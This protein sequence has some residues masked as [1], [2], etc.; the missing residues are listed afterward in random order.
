MTGVLV[1]QGDLRW[2]TQIR[3]IL[4]EYQRDERDSAYNST[5]SDILS[6]R[7]GVLGPDGY[8][9]LS[10]GKVAF[11][12]DQFVPIFNSL[13]TVQ[14]TRTAF[15]YNNYAYELMGQVIE[16]V[17]GTTIGNFLKESIMKPLGMTRTFDTRIPPSTKNVAKPYSILRNRTVYELGMPLV[18]QD[19]LFSAA[20]GIR[21]SVSDLLRFYN[22]LMDAGM[23]Q[24]GD[25]DRRISRNPLKQLKPIWTG[26]I[27]M[28]FSTL[29]EHSYAFGWVRAQ[30][31][32]TFGIDGPK[33]WKAIVG[34]GFPCRLAFYH[35]GI[36][37][38]FTS[39]S[40]LIPETRSAVVVL[41]NSGGLNE[42][43]MLVASAVLDTLFGA[44]IDD[45]AYKNLA[46]AGYKEAASRLSD[47]MKELKDGQQIDVPTRPL[48][49]YTGRYYN[50]LNNYFIDIQKNSHGGLLISF[51]GRPTDT[52]KLV[53]YESDKFFWYLTHDECVSRGRLTEFPMDYYLIKFAFDE[54]DTTLKDPVLYWKYDPDYPGDGEP[55]REIRSYSKLG[56]QHN[57]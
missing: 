26:M 19:G 15:I 27:S 47:V 11:P 49:D 16:K 31:P 34:K 40:A 20:G 13:P 12:R 3:H 32:S 23:S 57:I 30:L 42:A 22:A 24:L 7:T 56:L 14:P 33:P 45:Q 9:M 41:T 4:P 35:Q 37:Q 44:N 52:F 25:C 28:P 38:G 54:N 8:W 55:F 50:S 18:R 51:M 6:H 53:P 39:F 36:V 43:G 2:D 29:K 46:K 10:E 1:E 17:S 5:I 21:T 48:E